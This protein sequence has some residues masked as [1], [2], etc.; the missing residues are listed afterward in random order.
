MLGFLARG[1]GEGGEGLSNIGVTVDSI[2]NRMRPR[3]RGAEKMYGL[4]EAVVFVAAMVQ[5]ESRPKDT[6]RSTPAEI[7]NTH[8][9]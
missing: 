5:Y 7:A 8:T 1:G 3:L 6:F 4:I 9:G 2:V